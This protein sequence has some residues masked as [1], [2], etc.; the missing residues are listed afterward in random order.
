MSAANGGLAA[1]PVTACASSRDA[2]QPFRD[3]SPDDVLAMA[4]AQLA[5]NDAAMD[6][7][8]DGDNIPLVAEGGRN[9]FTRLNHQLRREVGQRLH[10]A[11]LLSGLSQKEAMLLLGQR[12][13]TQI[14]LWEMGR[15][16]PP[17]RE[18]VSAANLYGV[19]IDYLCNQTNEPERDPA[20]A[21]REATLRG[22]RNTLTRATELII[23]EVA[24]HARLIG[25]HAG[26]TRNFLASGQ[27]LVDAINSFVRQNLVEFED[28]RGGASVLRMVEEFE[29]TLVETR[30]AL[31]LH[32]AID[33]DLRRALSTIGQEASPDRPLA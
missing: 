30:T 16:L 12:N 25:P 11:R 32:D 3:V 23:G 15:R 18:I 28:Q 5:A 14:S 33:G 21:L 29:S 9:E 20:M 24:R 13:S 6:G 10:K 1:M 31:A 2:E 4:S 27:S 19:S 26:H 22:V 17:L 8:L 7:D